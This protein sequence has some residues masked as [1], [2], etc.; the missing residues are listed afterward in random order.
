MT[1]KEIV[2]NFLL[3]VRS[4]RTP[5][6]ASLYMADTVMAHQFNSDCPVTVY[7]S[8]ADYTKHVEEFKHIFGAYQF[9]IVELIAEKDKVY[10]RWIQ[11]GIHKNDYDGAS[12]TGL[13][14]I[15]YTSAVYR[16]AEGKIR[17]YWLQTD[18]M[19]MQL[20][21]EKNKQESR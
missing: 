1:A 18:R 2:S 21:L 7:R 14:L 11:R 12:A 6:R 16:V 3:E 15:E 19:G 5:E 4:G 9:E 17:E 13:P 10:A 8:P 20:Q